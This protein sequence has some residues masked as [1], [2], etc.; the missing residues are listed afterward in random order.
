[1]TTTRQHTISVK[2]DSG[3]VVPEVKRSVPEPK[4]GFRSFVLMRGGKV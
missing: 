4:Q 3:Y 2:A 1:M